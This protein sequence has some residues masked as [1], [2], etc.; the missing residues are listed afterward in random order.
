MFNRSRINSATA[1]FQLLHPILSPQELLPLAQEI[2]ML[3]S[4]ALAEINSNEFFRAG[5]PEYLAI[6]EVRGLL[7][8][9]QYN[10]RQLNAWTV[11]NA[12]HSARYLVNWVPLF[13]ADNQAERARRNAIQY[14]HK[15]PDFYREDV[16]NNF[17]DTE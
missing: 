2:E 14:Q 9:I 5:N 6:S 17:E 7:R 16:A 3:A 13:Y 12:M 8:E 4:E 11:N 1:E 15:F 10:P